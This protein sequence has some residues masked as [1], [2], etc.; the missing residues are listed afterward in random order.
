MPPG[1]TE[2]T[3]IDRSMQRD[4][5]NSQISVFPSMT[6]QRAAV[7][8]VAQFLHGGKHYAGIIAEARQTYDAALRHWTD[9]NR[10]AYDAALAHY[11][12][13]KKQVPVAIMQGVCPTAHDTGFT[14]YADL[15]CLDIDTEKP[16]KG[17]NGNEWISNLPG[18][19]EQAKTDI[20]ARIPYVAYCGLS[21]GG[22]GLFVLVPVTDGRNH[23]AHWRALCSAFRTQGLHIDM[24]T[25][26]PAR[27]RI[28]SLDPNA[29]YN[30]AAQ[31]YEAVED[32][33]PPMPQPRAREQSINRAHYTTTAT[34]DAQRVYSCAVDIADRGI[35]I[36]V[37]YPEW[38]QAAA[39]IAHTF[40]ERGRSLF[41]SIAE[42]S[43][44]YAYRDNDTL[45][46]SMMNSAA[47]GRE[48]TLGSFFYLCKSYGV[49]VPATQ[50]AAKYTAPRPQNLIKKF[51]HDVTDHEPGQRGVGVSISTK[52]TPEQAPR[53]TTP[54]SMAE[55]M[56]MQRMAGHIAE[57]AQIVDNMRATNAE[58]D[59]FCSNF[60]VDYFGHDGWHMT[61]AQFDNFF[62]SRHECPY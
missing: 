34:D 59:E 53:S 37:N 16:H 40:G 60:A 29:Y 52:P 10:Q 3:H 36:T 7:R 49:R 6:N 58:F 51:G 17:T 50:N 38:L 32:E 33:A 4:I 21:I 13:L 57:G 2:K 41:H 44:K 31:V 28:I 43:P 12:D 14:A 39:A 1:R 19:W 24:A 46:T 5:F 11:G 45:Y 35:D 56:E 55:Q 18:G 61:A 42:Q 20:I 27:K 25:K 47:Q 23:A 54:M 8:T 15:I 9:G 30:H 48:C 22:H 26:N 62:A